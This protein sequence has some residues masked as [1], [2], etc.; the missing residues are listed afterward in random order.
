MDVL[1]IILLILILLIPVVITFF[2]CKNLF[3]KRKFHPEI[4]LLVTV[5]VGL[6]FYF[7]YMNSQVTGAE[8]DQVI[9]KGQYHVP[10]AGEYRIS[11]IILCVIGF[12]SLLGIA[13]IP[14]VYVSPLAAVFMLSGVI[15]LNLLNV[16]TALQFAPL[17]F[18]KD[19]PYIE[20]IL[21]IEPLLFHLNIVLVSIYFMRQSVCEQMTLMEEKIK[22]TRSVWL[23]KLY[24]FL[25][26]SSNWPV[27]VF[28][29]F[30]YLLIILEIILILFG[31][32]AAG[33]V[34][35]FTMTADWTFSTQVPPPPKEYSGH[36]LCT[37]AAGGHKKIVRPLRF[38]K[39]HG[40]KIVVNRQL[41]AANAFEELIAEKM[42]NFHKKIR[43]FYDT[44][45]YPLSCI[46][47]TPLRADIV[48][49]LMKPLEW[50][51]IFVLYMFSTNPEERISR[52]YS[53]K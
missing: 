37:V 39:R 41:M 47:T 17:F 51:F 28:A 27:I 34:N 24:S 2:N 45:G 35:M 36:Y 1:F 43:H 29:A 52:Q 19:P 21:A 22:K 33:P 16:F 30:G 53:L 5:F 8:W 12:A 32:G 6:F 44:H 48:Y 9:Y 50:I 14:A 25:T 31:Q 40:V 15:L 38:G 10:I 18:T 3:S 4:M 7:L 20:G 42:P 13:L 11:F 49:L 46:I 26:K 23:Q